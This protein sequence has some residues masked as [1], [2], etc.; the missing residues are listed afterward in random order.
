MSAGRRRIIHQ[1]EEGQGRAD[2]VAP[3]AHVQS[4]VAVGE[5]HGVAVVVALV[6]VR[7]VVAGSVAQA[8]L[9]VGLRRVVASEASR[10]V[11]VGDGSVVAL[12]ARRVQRSVQFEELR[13]LFNA[14]GDCE[15]GAAV[16]EDEDFGEGVQSGF[17]GFVEG[18]GGAEELFLYDGFYVFAEVDDV[19]GGEL[20][21]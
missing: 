14:H 5:E 2:L 18:V 13:F 6:T 21:L 20:E 7:R 15:V 4:R 8:E 3:G 1:V 11:G 9:V 10:V 19:R 16:F 17:V 12:V